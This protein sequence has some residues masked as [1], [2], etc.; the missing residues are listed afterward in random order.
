MIPHIGVTQET[1]ENIDPSD[2]VIPTDT[3]KTINETAF[4]RLI[5]S[6]DTN[7]EA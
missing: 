1:L 7:R 6:R 5:D 2:T 4:D 3:I